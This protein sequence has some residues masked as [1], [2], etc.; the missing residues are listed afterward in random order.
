MRIVAWN[1]AKAFHKKIDRLLALRPDVAVVSECASP[2]VLARK[3]RL[4][5]FSADPIWHGDGPNYGVGVFFFNGAAG[6]RHYRFDRD[7]YLLHPVEV[8][9]PRRFNLLA[10]WAFPYGLRKAEPGPLNDGTEF[11]RRFLTEKDAVL[12]GDF[13]HN[14]NWDA[15]GWASNF[16]LTVAHVDSL[17]LVSAYHEKSREEHGKESCPTFYFRRKLNDPFHIDYI[18]VPRAWTERAF[19]LH[20]GH[21]DDWVAAGTGMNG[22]SLSDH[23]PLTFVTDDG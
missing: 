18:F 10:V 17:G 11:Y 9:K 1:C 19:D 16:G 13:N 12:A 20:V 14:V 4:P 2:D 8:T 3:C 6:R 22:K 15:D 23:V 21:Y 5:E 7:L